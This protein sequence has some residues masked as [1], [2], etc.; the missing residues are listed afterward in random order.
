MS[1]LRYTEENNFH[2]PSLE[3][4][5]HKLSQSHQGSQT[6]IFRMPN[7][8]Q[9]RRKAK[10]HELE[11]ALDE[12]SQRMQSP[13]HKKIISDLKCVSTEKLVAVRRKRKPKP[14]KKM[15]ST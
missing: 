9:I 14:S 3:S 6:N 4:T 12:M 13:E 7:K 5:N 2:Y 11:K 8:D 15:D 10:S 1:G